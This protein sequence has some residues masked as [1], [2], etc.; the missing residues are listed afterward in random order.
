MQLISPATI[1]AIM[2]ATSA[3]GALAA[4]SPNPD[5]VYIKRITY[6]GSGCPSGSV[7]SN[8]SNDAKAFTLL[9]DSYL[10]EAGPGIPNGMA[11]SRCRIVVDLKVPQGWSYTLFTV[12]YRGYMSLDP[13]VVATQNSSYWFQSTPDDVLALSSDYY[14]PVDKDYFISDTVDIDELVW[15]PCGKSRA[16]NLETKIKVSNDSA[17]DNSGFITVD[18]IDGELAHIYGIKWIKC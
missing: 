18:S 9:F 7:A 6:S 4:D 16:L 8:L 3:H 12:D 15:S 5:Q 14:G 2:L 10:A 1:T 11:N 17:P 13:G